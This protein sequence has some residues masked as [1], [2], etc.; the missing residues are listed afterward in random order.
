[1]DESQANQLID[2][3]KPLI[4]LMEHF[5]SG[6]DALRFFTGKMSNRFRQEAVGEQCCWCKREPVS[7][8][9]AFCWRALVSPRFAFT[10]IN[11]LMLLAGRLSVSI[12]HTSVDF[13]TFHGL[14]EPCAKKAK[15]NR[16]CATAIKSISFF[17]LL[18]CL[19]MCVFGGGAA[20][21]FWA[22]SKDRKE[23]L[24]VFAIGVAGL[25]ASVFG[26]IWERN[27]RILKFVRSVG[28]KPF[29]L[30]KVIGK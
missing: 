19:G 12:Q 15:L 13:V 25:I 9:H 20:L 11:A 24:I 27:L 5:G 30:V 7:R 14:C 22:D 4:G 6:L 10:H 26:H 23:C 18:V 21:L 1:M 16:F 8:V 29:D 28:R 17:L 3:E 2:S